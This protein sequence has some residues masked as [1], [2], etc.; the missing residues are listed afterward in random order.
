[1]VG[2]EAKVDRFDVFIGSDFNDIISVGGFYDLGNSYNH[3]E[4]FGGAG[5]DIIFG[6]QTG[7]ELY[8]G[9]GNDTLGTYNG[10][11]RIRN[12]T[13]EQQ[14]SLFDTDVRTIL[15]GGNGNDLF[16]AG[17]SQE[18]F[19]GGA[20]IDRLLYRATTDL[21]RD[22]V[23]TDVSQEGVVVDLDAG[24]GNFGFA[25]GDVISGI[26]N[27][28]GSENGDDI[29][30]DANSN[31]LIGLGGDDTIAGAAGDDIISRRRRFRSV[32]WGTRPGCFVGRSRQ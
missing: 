7:G 18:T 31:W 15:D 4:A 6:A 10:L 22:D 20:G 13:Q 19:I 29:A 25:K 24:T 8:G 1:M 27:L 5:D 9:E 3:I 26:E 14:I 32:V 23:L 16:I 12:N 11:E 30:G 28:T 17:D 21:G 2:G